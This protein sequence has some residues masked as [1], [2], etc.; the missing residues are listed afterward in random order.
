MLKSTSAEHANGSAALLEMVL[1]P[2]MTFAN[3]RLE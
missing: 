1:D 3:A 2:F